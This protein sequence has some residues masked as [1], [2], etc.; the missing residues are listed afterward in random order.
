[1]RAIPPALAEHLAG[2]VTTTCRLLRIE[3]RDGV[4]HGLTTLDRDVEYQGV[5]YRTLSGCDVSVLATAAD[6]S[7]DNTEAFALLARDALGLQ[8]L[9]L[10]AGVLDDARW[11]LML[12]NWADLG[13]GHVTLDAGDVGRVTVRDGM[14]YAPELVSYSVRLRQRIVTHD[15]RLCRAEFG[16]PANSQ[17]GCGVDASALWVPGTVTAVDGD[18][19]ARIF[20]GDAA[21][22]VPGRL[23]WLTGN[24]AGPR[25]WPLD[26]A[27]LGTLVLMEDMPYPVEPG[28]TY[29]VRPDCAKTLPACQTYGNVINMKGEWY[30]PVGDGLEAQA[31]TAQV[32]GGVTGSVTPE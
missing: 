6:M 15:S 20:A 21:G 11:S 25:L 14:A 24:N 16:A 29:Q 7:A 26:A 19:P 22:S 18:E 10:L 23:Q 13:M 2:S 5:T 4:V 32:V 27:G 9:D 17:R 12:V 8:L 1:M 30:I 31:P 3:R 28:D